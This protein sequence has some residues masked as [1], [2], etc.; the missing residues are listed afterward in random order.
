MT[1]TIRL[2]NGKLCG[3]GAYVTS[4]RR[5]ANGKVPAD[6]KIVGF[7]DWP[8]TA[9]DILAALRRGLHRRIN[10]HDPHYNHG[11][12][13]HHDWQRAAGHCAAEVNTPRLI[14]RWVPT[15]FRTRLANRLYTD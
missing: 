1:S 10:Q 12:K 15:D 4:W 7:G 11:R 5:L 13:W 14:V 2:P 8:E 9:A 3:L 6:A